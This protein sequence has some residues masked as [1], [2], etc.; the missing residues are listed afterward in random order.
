MLK[1]WEFPN[2]VKIPGSLVFANIVIH[3]LVTIPPLNILVEIPIG[4]VGKTNAIS[5][6][7]WLAFCL[8]YGRFLHFVEA[9]RLFQ[10]PLELF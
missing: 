8:L 1:R 4:T 10:F 7:I 3:F 2:F 5:D 6:L 9:E